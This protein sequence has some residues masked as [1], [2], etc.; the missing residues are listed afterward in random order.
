MAGLLDFLMP[1]QSQ[2]PWSGMRQTGQSGGFLDTLLSPEVALPMAAQLMGGN[3][4]S[5]NFGNA[6][7]AAGQGLGERRKL[8]A[9]TRERNQT[10]EYLRKNRPDLAEMVAAGMPIS[11]AWQAVSSKKGQGYINAGG[12]NLFNSETGE[13]VSAP[14]GGVEGVAGLQPVW[15]RDS[16][17]GRPVLGQMRKDGTV[18]R[19]GMPEGVEAIGPYD[20][21]FDRAAGTAGGT[22]AGEAAGALPGASM[23]AQTIDA[24]I[25]DL[26]TDPYLPNMVGPVYG[27]TPNLT[28]D[29]ARVQGKIDQLKGGAF[30]QARQMLKGGG[31]ITDYEGKKAEEA[32]ARLS[33]A[34]NLQDFQQALDEFNYFVQVGLQKLQAQAGQMRME[35][36]GQP[37]PSG[38]VDYKQRYGLD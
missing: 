26:K 2:D 34:Q 35:R 28:S 31:A 19:S 24:Q 22:A 36:S 37:A 8:Q 27:R 30:L 1:R 5:A 11:E 7:M 25:Q 6:L 9:Q 18:V 32:Y 14:G 3:G 29:A 10:L 23:M 13:W 33:Q 4:N 21:N 12:G 16:K 20:V 38:P 15:L 17:T